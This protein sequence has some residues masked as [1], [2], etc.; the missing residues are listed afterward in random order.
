MNSRRKQSVNQV[1]EIQLLRGGALVS[2]LLGAFVNGSP[3]R[4]M[5]Q[6]AKRLPP[7]FSFFGSALRTAHS[8]Q[9]IDSVLSF[10]F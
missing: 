7:R 9:V 3:I 10:H 8:F 2:N 5:S 1:E 6:E 4:A